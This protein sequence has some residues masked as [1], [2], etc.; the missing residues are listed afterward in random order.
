MDEI[1]NGITYKN[2]QYTVPPRVKNN[3][4]D[5]CDIVLEAI[6]EFSLNTSKK[7]F[8][9]SNFQV[10]AIKYFILTDKAYRAL[11]EVKTLHEKMW[12]NVVIPLKSI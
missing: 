6:N 3:L 2:K 10:K 4:I 5:S 1:T 9:L 11:A 12:E 8:N 7:S